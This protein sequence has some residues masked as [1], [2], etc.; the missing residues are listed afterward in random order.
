VKVGDKIKKVGGYPQK[1]VSATD[2][3]DTVDKKLQEEKV[4]K[5]K[6]STLAIPKRHG[7]KEW[8]TYRCLNTLKARGKFFS[9]IADHLIN[10]P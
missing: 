4:A 6:C 8:K 3:V 9:R 2:L 1:M 10:R 5:Q 7:E